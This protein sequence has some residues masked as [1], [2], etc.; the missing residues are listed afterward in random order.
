MLAS[1]SILQ[2]AFRKIESTRRAT[3]TACRAP[4]GL[5]TRWRRYLQATPL[6]GCLLLIVLGVSSCGAPKPIR[7]YQLNPPALPPASAEAPYPITIVLGA[8]TSSHLYREDHI[9]YGTESEGMGVYEYQRW[10]EPPTEMIHELLLRELRGSHRF[11][12][13]YPLRSVIHGDYLLRGRLYDFKEVSGSSLVARVTFELEL[14]DNKSGATVWNNSYQHDEPVAGNDAAAVVA[15]LDKN[16][17]RGT[18][19]AVASIE[20]FFA[21]HPPPPAASQPAGQ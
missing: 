5:A 12:E 11:N 21:Q 2:S 1:P 20:Q 9:V 3:P 8:I 17:G 7:F 10:A 6:A 19:E 14:R 4:Q 13:V 18:A 15:A 16:I